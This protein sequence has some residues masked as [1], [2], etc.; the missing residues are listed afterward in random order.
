MSKNAA[1]VGLAIFGFG[2]VL[3]SPFLGGVVSGIAMILAFQRR[4]EGG[5]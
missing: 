4:N 1:I 5:A 2:L 3:V